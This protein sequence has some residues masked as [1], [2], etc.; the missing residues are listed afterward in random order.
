MAPASVVE[1]KS[2]VLVGKA[3]L[4]RRLM[5]ASATLSLRRAV[6]S[7]MTGQVR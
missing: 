5:G 2:S 6:S 1:L 7:V 4:P 3:K